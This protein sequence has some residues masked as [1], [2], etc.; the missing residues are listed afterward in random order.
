MALV[1]ARAAGRRSKRS[2]IQPEQEGK[3]DDV[4]VECRTFG[5]CARRRP[6]Q[7]AGAPARPEEAEEK[8]KLRLE[9]NEGNKALAV[10]VLAKRERQMAEAQSLIDEEARVKNQ[11]MFLGAAKAQMEEKHFDQLL[12]GAERELR[13]KQTRARV[14]QKAYEDTMAHAQD[15]RRQLKR[16]E[17][18]ATK[19]FYR[20][21]DA[22]VRE[23][24]V[25][26]AEKKTLELEA[27][28]A[29]MRAARVRD[30]ALRGVLEAAQPYAAMQAKKSLQRGLA[31]TKRREERARATRSAAMES[32]L[33][34]DTGARR[35]QGRRLSP[36]VPT[37]RSAA[38]RQAL[39][40]APWQARYASG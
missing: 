6:R 18:A 12:L 24:R 2:V 3:A 8:E 20:Q 11:Q 30:K 27:K 26:L 34:L 7:Q 14:E 9:R 36:S 29:A 32:G 1:E 5:A 35:S 37:S 31:A 39:A 19:R 10:R 33:R 13:E 25:E 4:R 40:P 17:R 15:V 28:K 22:V 23:Q 38:W 21:Q 16:K